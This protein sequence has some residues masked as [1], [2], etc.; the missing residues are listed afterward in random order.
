MAMDLYTPENS[1]QNAGPDMGNTIYVNFTFPYAQMLTWDLAH[2]MMQKSDRQSKS[3]LRPGRPRRR[4]GA[5]RTTGEQWGRQAYNSEPPLQDL[6]FSIFL[7]LSTVLLQLFLPAAETVPLLR[8]SA[9]HLSTYSPDRRQAIG[10]PPVQ[11][12]PPRRP[13]TDR[14]QTIFAALTT[15]TSGEEEEEE[16]EGEEEEEEKYKYTGVR[17]GG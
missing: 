1:R 16:E 14:F 2:K 4:T 3:L 15:T 17:T 10:E 9:P 11:T 12:N 13:I 7:P 6:H 5:P 8:S